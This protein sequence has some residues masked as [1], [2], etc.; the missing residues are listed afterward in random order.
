VNSQVTWTT[1]Q[2]V[3]PCA[4]SP[5]RPGFCISKLCPRWSLEL[6]R[7]PHPSERLAL[8]PRGSAL[9]VAPLDEVASYP[10]SCILRLCRRPSYELPRLWRPSA[11]P[12]V[13][14][15]VAP[16]FTP[17]VT[18]PDA[19][20]WV[21]PGF[22]IFRPCRRW[23]FELPRI[24]HP[25]AHLARSPGV[26]PAVPP[27]QLRLSI[28]SA[29]LPRFLHLPAVPATVPR[30][31]PRFVSFG[32]SGAGASGCPSASRFQLRLPVRLQIAPPLSP[33]GF[34]SGFESSGF[35]VVS[36]LWR[37]LMV[38]RVA[39][40]SAPSGFAVPASSGFP[41]SCIYGWVDD[42]FPVLLELCIL[43]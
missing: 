16:L 34:A 37:R 30:V 3:Q 23:I 14:L 31:A 12:W 5:G 7:F 26:S 25:S 42:D 20:P 28:L 40:V 15:Q 35:P 27:L 36:F 13:E 2:P 39:S 43:G 21:A 8:K 29:G 10:A 4:K 19:S 6:P 38:P 41:E 22:R 1:H 9:P 11:L 33:S 32:A 17:S 18:P 24:S